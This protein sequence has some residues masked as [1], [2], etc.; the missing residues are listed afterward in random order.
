VSSIE[1]EVKIMPIEYERQA[2]T[3]GYLPESERNTAYYLFSR[4]ERYGCRLRKMDTMSVDYIRFFGTPTAGDPDY[5]REMRNEIV[6]RQLTIAEMACYFRD[7]VTVRVVKRDDTKKIYERI[8]DHLIA[9]RDALSSL[10][11][12]QAPIEDLL[13][14]DEFAHKVYEHARWHFKDPY[15]TSLLERAMNARFG[16]MGILGQGNHSLPTVN[17]PPPE[18]ETFNDL[19]VGRRQPGSVPRTGLNGQAPS[20]ANPQG[21]G[22]NPNGGLTGGFAGTG[23]TNDALQFDKRFGRR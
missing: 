10:N 14:L 5:D 20:Y 16:N 15:T 4:A 17:N 2:T 11:H 22:M 1:V 18:R 13:V 9:W 19:F 3:V 8:T 21:A 7:G 6:D 12:P 23:D